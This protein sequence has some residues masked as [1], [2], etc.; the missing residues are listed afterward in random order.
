MKLRSKPRLDYRQL[1]NTGARVLKMEGEHQGNDKVG[2]M[3]GTELKTREDLN[4]CLEIYEDVNDFTTKSEVLE[5][6]KTVSELF[7]VY[8]HVNPT[9]RGGGAI[10]APPR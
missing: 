1:H 2:I 10:M 6:I 3:K 5:A 4:F 9:R 8:R 7:Q